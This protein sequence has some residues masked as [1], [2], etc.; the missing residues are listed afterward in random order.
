[1]REGL[2]RI[3]FRDML[4]SD[5]PAGLALCRASAWNQVVRDWEC[6]LRLSPQG[7]RAA[8]KDD[9]VVGTVATL[10]YQ[11]HRHRNLF[12]WISMVLVAPAERRQGIGSQLMREA[13]DMLRG[14]ETIRLDA[15]PA[16]REVYRNLDF[17]DE[18]ELTRMVVPAFVRPFSSK[19]HH[20]TLVTENNLPQVFE[21]DYQVFGADRSVLLKW[22]YEG[23][24]QYSRIIF[25]DGKISGCIFG[26]DGFRFAH[27]G[28]V[29]AED[30]RTAQLL[31][32]ACLQDHPERSFILD[33]SHHDAEWLSW[34]QSVGFKEQRPFTRMYR[35]VNCHPGIPAKQYA[36]LGPEFG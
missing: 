29:I 34:L 9:R 20:T 30:C 32:I 33:A 13:L 31:L 6:F 7:C 28:P 11:D 1:M 14:E 15:T 25:H 4:F 36:I 18:Y 23:A 22:L 16:G 21:M 27:L 8:I 26:R 17:V 2:S 19:D 3:A 5:I 24:P 10:K 35:G 12:S